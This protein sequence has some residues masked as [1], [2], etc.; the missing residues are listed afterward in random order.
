MEEVHIDFRNWSPKYDFSEFNNL[1]HHEKEK[2][3]GMWDGSASNGFAMSGTS[4]FMMAKN[5]L[6]K[7]IKATI[8]T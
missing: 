6:T 1:A 2:S 5:V 7:S 3:N 8:L 4:G